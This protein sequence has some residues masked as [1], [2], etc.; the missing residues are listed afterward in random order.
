MSEFLSEK[1]LQR[2]D[3]AETCAF[4]SPVP[5]QPISNGEFFPGHQS[6]EQKQ[7]QERQK[8]VSAPPPPPKNEKATKQDRPAA[9]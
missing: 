5:T 4:E 9:H 2:L 8:V 1:E 3:P 6:K 7:V